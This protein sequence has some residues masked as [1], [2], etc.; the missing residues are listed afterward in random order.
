MSNNQILD[1]YFHSVL[2]STGIVVAVVSII[3][4][5]ALTTFN[6]FNTED[7][8]DKHC[9]IAIYRYFVIYFQRPIIQTISQIQSIMYTVL[10]AIMLSTF[11]AA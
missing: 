8:S 11:I 1:A 4:N 2:S 6:M 3:Y 10:Y 9:A 7:L 5:H